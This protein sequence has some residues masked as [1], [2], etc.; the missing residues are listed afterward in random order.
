V[1]EEIRQV[2]LKK[3]HLPEP[4]AADILAFLAKSTRSGET[5]DDSSIRIPEG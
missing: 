4:L 1:L 3:I 2:F 5:E